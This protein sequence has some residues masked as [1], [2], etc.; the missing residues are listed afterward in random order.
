MVATTVTFK[1]QLRVFLW[2]N[3]LITK[4]QVKATATVIL[5]PVFMVLL[6]YLLQQSQKRI[7][8]LQKHGI[9]IPAVELRPRAIIDLN[10]M[11]YDCPAP[12]PGA[13]PVTEPRACGRQLVYGPASS[14]DA[15][16][17]DVER[18]M[19]AFGADLRADARKHLKALP[20]V[21]ALDAY[22]AQHRD[23]VF[24]A[25]VFDTLGAAAAAAAAA[26][27]VEQGAETTRPGAG[28]VR[29]T[30]RVDGAKLPLSSSFV[31]KS[32]VSAKSALYNSSGFL[33]IQQRVTSAIFQVMGKR[34]AAPASLQWFSYPQPTLMATL[35]D[36]VGVDFNVSLGDFYVSVGF[37]VIA[38]RE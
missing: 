31:D 21:A 37:G 14:D 24:A 10:G 8:E 29:F 16:G 18:V 15:A 13:A 34:V 5:M 38:T 35:S 33:S 32:W 26:A 36:L 17:G 28:A 30:I 27:D 2:R 23:S 7:E 3:F 19:A 9:P 11:L 22:V 1:S 20:T 25:V 6:M 4:R 12:L